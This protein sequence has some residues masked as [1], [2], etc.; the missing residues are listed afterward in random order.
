MTKEFS[1]VVSVQWYGNNLEANTQEEY[2]AKLK[3]L[4]LEE[5]NISLLDDD[6]GEIEVSEE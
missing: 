3:E 4:F 2:I 1:S 5:Y 6:I